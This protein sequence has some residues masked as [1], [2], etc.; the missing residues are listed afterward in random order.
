MEEKKYTISSFNLKE[1]LN[2][3]IYINDNKKSDFIFCW[4]FDKPSYLEKVELC[5]YN[6]NNNSCKKLTKYESGDY[7]IA[8]EQIKNLIF[9]PNDEIWYYHYIDSIGKIIKINVFCSKKCTLY[10]YEF[11]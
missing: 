8:P 7:F 10:I 9:L 6:E 5:T 4:K 2:E 3:N 11:N 1:G